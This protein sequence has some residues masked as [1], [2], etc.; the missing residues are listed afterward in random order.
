MT[1]Q[2][3][4]TA[5]NR[6]ANVFSG[7]YKPER[8]QLIWREMGSLPANA[9]NRMIDRFIGEARQPPLIQEFREAASMEREK[10]HERE[11]KDHTKDSWAFWKGTAQPE[12]IGWMMKAVKA[13]LK[14]EMDDNDWNAFMKLLDTRFGKDMPQ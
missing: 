11:K 8:T 2:E 14:K 5:M 4:Q 9:F 1:A 6:L 7:A 12:E 10:I 13:R 3:F